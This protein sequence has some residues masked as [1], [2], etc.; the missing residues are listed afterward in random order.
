MVEKLTA[1]TEMLAAQFVEAVR[2][3]M[4]QALRKSAPE[5]QKKVLVCGFTEDEDSLGLTLNSICP[6]V[7]LADD[8]RRTTP[9]TYED[10]DEAGISEEKEIAYKCCLYPS[11]FI[12]RKK[13]KED[14]SSTYSIEYELYLKYPSTTYYRGPRVIF[15]RSNQLVSGMELQGW[16]SLNPNAQEIFTTTSCDSPDHITYW[17]TLICIMSVGSHR[18]R[19]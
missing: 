12:R 2:E 14:I 19:L 10:D 7:Y 1:S 16:F 17:Q 9:L 13:T 3:A 8:N 18:S 11:C 4:K 15:Y 6:L 5:I